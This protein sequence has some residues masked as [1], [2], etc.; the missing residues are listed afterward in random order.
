MAISDELTR[1]Q[2]AK[3]DI[4]ASIEAKGVTV[5]SDALID[6]YADYV[7]EIQTGGGTKDY[8]V[9]GTE[10]DPTATYSG[11]FLPIRQIVTANIPSG[12]TSIGRSAFSDNTNITSITI[13][14]SVTSIGD[15]CFSGC[16]GLTSIEIPNNVTSIGVQAFMGCTSLTS[17]NIPS[18]VTTLQGVFY[19][20]TSLTS[21]NIPSGVT[22]ISFICSDCGNL[23]SATIP[24]DIT[25]IGEQAF[26]NC[27]K[28]K[29]VNSNVDGECIIPSGVTSINISAFS[30]CEHLT[31]VV[32]PDSVTTLGQ[33]A[34]WTT[35]PFNWCTGLLT[36]IIGTGITSIGSQTFF[37]CIRLTSIT[38]KATTPP[39][40]VDTK[41]FTNTNNCPIYVPSE[42]VDA[43]K[44]ATNWST[45]ASRIQ[46]IPSE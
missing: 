26:A 15:Y 8:I 1:I 25:T 39:T 44:A 30:R 24:N 19:G 10:Y 41:T 45:Y 36:V 14:N 6:Q 22:N 40:L 37:N 9:E 2:T 27:K 35:G 42:S 29:R 20:C 34:T 31:S 38:I 46:A 5:P 17:I 3:A 32:I 16:T 21:I 23:E 7:D 18:G 4:K 12:F 11:T 28:L 13:P 33:T 43:Y